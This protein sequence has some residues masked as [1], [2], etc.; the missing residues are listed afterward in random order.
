MLAFRTFAYIRVGLAAREL[1]FDHDISA[2][3]GSETWVDALL[4]DPAHHA[5]SP[6]RCGRSPARSPQT[7]STEDDEQLGPDE[8]ARERFKAFAREQLG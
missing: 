1:L 2:Y 8:A 7:R 6:R 4:K 3:D 5:A